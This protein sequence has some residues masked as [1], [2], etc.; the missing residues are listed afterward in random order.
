MQING[1][2]LLLRL[3]KS[4]CHSRGASRL[5][6][7]EQSLHFPPVLHFHFLSMFFLRLLWILDLLCSGKDSIF[8]FYFNWSHRLFPGGLPHDWIF[9]RNVPRNQQ[10]ERF[11]ARFIDDIQSYAAKAFADNVFV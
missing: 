6:L 4:M 8:D 2:P 7:L 9:Y 1:P 3:R 10:E 11:L 5:K